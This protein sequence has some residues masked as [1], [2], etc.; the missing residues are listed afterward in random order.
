[1]WRLSDTR[2]S[3][4]ESLY[5]KRCILWMKTGMV[6][7]EDMSYVLCCNDFDCVASSNK[8]GDWA[9]VDFLKFELL[10][11]RHCWQH[12]LGI[13]QQRPFTKLI[14]F[15]SIAE[16]SFKQ[17]RFRFSQE[18]GVCWQLE[19]SRS[20][21]GEKFIFWIANEWT[22]SKDYSYALLFGHRDKRGCWRS[23][24]EADPSATN[25]FNALFTNLKWIQTVTNQI[26]LK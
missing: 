5:L 17:D 1:M 23:W 12:P 9:H 10:L 13:R 24:E 19:E 8:H 11:N 4:V 14:L 20:R 3:A 22:E 21:A 18:A 6:I 7:K 25:D 15:V 26:R 16:L 2:T